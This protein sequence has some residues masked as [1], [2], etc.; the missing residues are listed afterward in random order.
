MRTIDWENIFLRSWRPYF[1]IA[2][3][4]ILV[5]GK[6]VSFSLVH[7]DDIYLLDNARLFGYL[8]DLPGLFLQGLFLRGISAL[9]RPVL[10]ISIIVDYWL[11]GY[12]PGMYHLTNL[13]LHLIASGLVF[14]LLKKLGYK[15]WLALIFAL[16]FT[17][18]PVNTNTVAWI[19]GR[20]D[21][22]LAIFTFASF[23]FLLD[24]LQSKHI[25][26]Y[27]RHMG[28]FALALLTKENA[29]VIPLLFLPYLYL[30]GK[31]K[32]TLRAVQALL[33]G[34]FATLLI[35]T[36]IKQAV[37][38]GP[39]NQAV[40]VQVKELL[41]MLPAAAP[42]I[43]LFLGKAIIPVNLSGI[44]VAAQ[45]NLN[46]GLA[47]AVLL[48]LLFVFAK[49]KRFSMMA[50]GA[51]WFILF[52]LPTFKYTANLLMDN[53]VYL[54]LFGLAIVLLEANVIKN[55]RTGVLAGA[56]IIVLFGAISFR[57]S[58]IYSNRITFWEHAV[59]T[60]P[61]FAPARSDLANSY[62]DAGRPQEAEKA[63][64]KAIELNPNYPGAWFGLAAMYFQ[65]GRLA[66]SEKA[67]RRAIGL[68]ANF[69]EAYN[70]L[71]LI[72][73]QRGHFREAEALFNK[74]L[75]INPLCEAA[76]L[77]LKLLDQRLKK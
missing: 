9:Y 72:Y 57:L 39:A 69:F 31:E 71:G 23:N 26:D 37:L 10:V 73:Q 35:W 18:H 33:A 6:T 16:V 59:K 20:N 2:L 66:D 8:Q 48:V 68:D 25:K 30:A 74:A 53:R 54:P 13:V 27:A 64:A 17:V 65:Q 46:F 70:L 29:A 24:Y 3:A 49:P 77:N 14:L 60:A 56:L 1:W 41:M 45:A 51:G 52:L 32:L 4:G 28:F 11:G 55:I 21:S 5:F 62:L 19:P 75:R 42:A 40:F 58:D 36:L 43:L 50:F 12:D 15:D 67:C 34:W 7:Y 47:A 61:N 38:I 22:L 76:Q 63:F 44:T